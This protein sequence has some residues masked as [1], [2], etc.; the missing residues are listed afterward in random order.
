MAGQYPDKLR[1]GVSGGPYYCDTVHFAGFLSQ[2]VSHLKY[3][4]HTKAGTQLQEE[5][6]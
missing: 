3:E 6:G 2:T 4:F 1:T 5:S